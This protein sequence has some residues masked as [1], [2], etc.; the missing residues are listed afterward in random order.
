MNVVNVGGLEHL[1]IARVLKGHQVHDNSSSSN[2]IEDI[3]IKIGPV[4][5]HYPNWALLCVAEDC[6]TGCRWPN[7]SAFFFSASSPQVFHFVVALSEACQSH[8]QARLRNWWHSWK[9]RLADWNKCCR[10]DK[11]SSSALQWKSLVKAHLLKPH[12]RLRQLVQ[13]QPWMHKLFSARGS[14]DR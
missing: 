5:R 10:R 1:N 6:S 7:N 2:R 14:T 4:G 12:L 8:H 13:T 9:A 11:S 3:G